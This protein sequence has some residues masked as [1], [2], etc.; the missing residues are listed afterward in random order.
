MLCW[1]WG[2]QPHTLNAS[3]L[4]W[5]W[6]LFSKKALN[7]ASGSY[8]SPG[9]LNSGRNT[10][11]LPTDSE[12][13]RLVGCGIRTA[14]SQTLVKQ[15]KGRNYISFLITS[16][17]STHCLWFLWQKRRWYTVSEQGGRGDEEN[18]DE[19]VRLTNR[20]RCATPKDTSPLA[21]FCQVGPT[22]HTLLHPS[23]IRHSTPSIDF[24]LLWRWHLPQPITSP[25]PV[26]W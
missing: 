21:Y 10:T 23:S 2:H 16:E 5:H 17:I 9:W 7:E 22:L 19:V 4:P 20:A 26:N 12:A 1:P 6:V 11:H 8:W 13:W 14:G 24:C 25:V 3:S 15:F 18:E